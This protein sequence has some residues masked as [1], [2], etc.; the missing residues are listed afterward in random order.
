MRFSKTRLAP[1]PTGFLHPGNAYSFAITLSLAKK[2][3]A[4]VLLR[5]DDLDMGR[6]KREYIDDIFETLNFLGMHWDEGPRDHEEFLSKFS[7]EKRLSEYNKILGELISSNLLYACKCT[8]HD[9]HTADNKCDCKTRKLPLDVEEANWR[10]NTSKPIVLKVRSLEGESE[11]ALPVNM[12]DFVVR[13]K[14][15]LP[16]Y[17]LASFTDDLNFG[18]DLIVR[19]QD[20]WESTLAQ[21]YLANVLNKQ[22]FCTC[23]FV[24]HPLLYEKDG[25]KMSKSAGDTPIRTMRGKNL[26]AEEIHEMI[27]KAT[28]DVT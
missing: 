14:N 22:Q 27:R 20:L 17:Q 25:R 13:R 1:T 15:G 5:I 18:I 6:V 7:Q 3:G 10:V 11:H 21:L 16:S 2:H 4:S 24:H 8:R 26:R 9:L 19:G 12:K 28:G 23:T